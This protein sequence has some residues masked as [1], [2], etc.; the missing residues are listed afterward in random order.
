MEEVHKGP[1]YNIWNTARRTCYDFASGSG[2]DH[3][4]ILSTC[5]SNASI[6]SIWQGAITGAC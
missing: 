4:N 2:I 6:R 3:S 1:L 5:I